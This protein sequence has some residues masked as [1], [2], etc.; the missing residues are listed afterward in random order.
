MTT[1][2]PGT[3]ELLTPSLPKGGGAI[4]SIGTTWGA[5]G[6]TG[7]ASFEV[8]LPLSPG[9][10][11][12]PALSLSYNSALGNGPF[13]TGWAASASSITRSTLKGVPAYNSED[14]FIGPSGTELVPERTVQGVLEV[15]SADHFNGHPLGSSYTVV[16]YLPRH[17]TA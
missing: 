13:G 1:Q 9:R 2:Q 11:F 8:P 4:Q 16:R 7:A 14:V 12:D 10:G 6:M 5:V 3:K 15:S 17:E